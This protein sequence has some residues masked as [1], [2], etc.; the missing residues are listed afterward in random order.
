M[1]ELLC[2]GLCE[3]PGEKGVAEMGEEERCWWWWLYGGANV[4]FEAFV[5]WESRYGDL[6]VRWTLLLGFI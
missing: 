4:D 6:L 2:L 5:G 3:G 1:R